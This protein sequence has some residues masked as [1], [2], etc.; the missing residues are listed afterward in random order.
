VEIDEA[1]IWHR[2]YNRRRRLDGFW[3][4][5]N[6]FLVGVFSCLCRSGVGNI[7]WMSLNSG[8]GQAQ[9]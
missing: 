4:V 8:Y 2:K 9:L 3:V 1:K 6:A 5:L 7:F